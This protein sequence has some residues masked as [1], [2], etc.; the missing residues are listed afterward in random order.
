MRHRNACFVDAAGTGALLAQA[1]GRTSAATIA[2][3]NAQTESW[4]AGIGE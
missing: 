3:L 4:S 1:E 2:W